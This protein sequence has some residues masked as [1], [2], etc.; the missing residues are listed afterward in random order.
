MPFVQSG[1]DGREQKSTQIAGHKVYYDDSSMSGV[2]R[3]RDDLD[4]NESKVFF[5]QARNSS[6]ADFE[7]DQEGQ[8]SLKYHNGAYYL[9]RR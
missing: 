8:Y 1:S 7:D 2:R 3:L 5:N 9:T 6:L 4:L